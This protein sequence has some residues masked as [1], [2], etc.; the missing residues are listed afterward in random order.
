MESFRNAD[1]QIVILDMVEAIRKNAQY[2]SDIDGKI[3]DGDHGINMNKGFTMCGERL[4][5]STSGFS[6]SLKTLG[7]VL[8]A[9]IGGSMGPLYGTLFNEMAKAAKDKETIDAALLEQMLARALAAVVTLGNAKVGDKSMLDALSPAVDALKAANASGA[10]FAEAVTR[11]AH[12]AETG[13]DST[14]DMVSK[15]GRSSR[16]GERSRGV[17]DAGAASCALLLSSMAESIKKLVA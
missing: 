16:L 12:A 9:E 4:A 17:L 1:G 10:S 8:L 6:D 2:L 13:R 7:R 3:G 15:I 5:G 11:M 14:K